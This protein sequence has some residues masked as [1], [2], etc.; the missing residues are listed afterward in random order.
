MRI[1]SDAELFEQQLGTGETLVWSGR[2]SDRLL[3]RSD[4]FFVLAGT[5]LGVVAI[6]AFVASLIALFGGDGAASFIG[7]VVSFFAG[8]LALFLVFGRLIRRYRHTQRNGYAITNRRVIQ[9]TAAADRSLDPTPTFV[10]FS[11]NPTTALTNHFERRGTITV[12]D[13]KIENINDAAV[14]YELLSAE[15]AKARPA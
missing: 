8:V 6:A 4:Y 14:I 12:G 13:I 5:V 3:I 10:N 9:L 2:G 1:H 11:E 7:L 15:L